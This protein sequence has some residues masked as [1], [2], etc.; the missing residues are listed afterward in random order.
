VLYS[1][2]GESQVGRPTTNFHHGK[3]QEE[4]PPEDVETQTPETP[5]GEPPQKAYLAEVSLL[6]GN[7]PSWRV[8]L[9][10]P[11]WPKGKT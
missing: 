5:Q 3:P 2:R 11:P 9:R 1:I 10:V 6:I 4:A 8:F 7:P